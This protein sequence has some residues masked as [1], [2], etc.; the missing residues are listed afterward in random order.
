VE[1]VTPRIAIA[2]THAGRAGVVQHVLAGRSQRRCRGAARTLVAILSW[3][4]VV[5]SCLRAQQPKPNEFQVKAAYLY[6]FGR[7]VAWPGESAQDKG[8]SFEIC[9]LGMDPFGQTLDVTLA[10]ETISGKSVRAKRISKPQDADGCRIVFIS[11]SEENHLKDVLAALEKTDVLTVSDIPG[12]S[13]RGGMIGFILDG[14]RVRFDVNLASAQGAGLTLSS[15][16]LKV[17]IDVKRS[18]HS[19]D[20]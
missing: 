10:S 9:V 2:T 20:L 3:S 4:L 13:Q 5:V 8:G 16:L 19:G 6:N 17:A 12:F 15:E 14:S 11:S 18:P 1:K 7:F